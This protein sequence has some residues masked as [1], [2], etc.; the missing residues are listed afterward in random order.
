MSCGRAPGVLAQ[1]SIGNVS[2]ASNAMRETENMLRLL[3]SDVSDMTSCPSF[4]REVSPGS[5]SDVR[6]PSAMVMPWSLMARLGAESNS[7]AIDR[8]CRVDE[9]QHGA[10]NEARVN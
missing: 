2:A 10:R 6:Q 9:H 4:A 1:S 8:A 5:A 7:N 3:V